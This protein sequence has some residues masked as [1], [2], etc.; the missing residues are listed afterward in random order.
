MAGILVSEARAARD[1]LFRIRYRELRRTYEA[2]RQVW[3]AH[4]ELYEEQI[5][6]DREALE[7]ARPDW[8][9]QN[10]ATVVGAIT[11]ILGAAITVGIVAAID[12][13]VD[14]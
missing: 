8:W 3:G 4:R 2:D 14:P 6:R 5:R 1:A 10:D 13:V 9:E 11:F 12:Y 7:Q